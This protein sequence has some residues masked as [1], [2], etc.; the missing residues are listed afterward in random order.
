LI[1]FIIFLAIIVLVTVAPLMIAGKIL[2]AANT[3]FFTCLMLVLFI[4]AI[5]KGA[6][7][8]FSNPGFAVVAAVAATGAIVSFMMETNYIKGI[9]ISLLTIGVM[10]VL[11][12]GLAG[13]GIATGFAEVSGGT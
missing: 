1:E 2:G 7:I 8:I 3:G 5:E 12:A 6:G 13:L 11:V 4:G 10:Y 9:T